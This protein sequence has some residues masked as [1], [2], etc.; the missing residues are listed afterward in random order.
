MKIYNL[1]LTVSR[2]PHFKFY[3][4]C[5]K[6]DSLRRVL[7]PFNKSLLK[8]VR[9]RHKPW[10]LLQI[11]L[12]GFAVFNTFKPCHGLVYCQINWTR[13][14]IKTCKLEWKKYHHTGYPRRGHVIWIGR[15]SHEAEEV[16]WLYVSELFY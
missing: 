11:D 7:T 13:M 5:F 10:S 12:L 9:E 8:V 3:K 15:F 6:L 2:S 4:K 16:Y 14:K 1:R